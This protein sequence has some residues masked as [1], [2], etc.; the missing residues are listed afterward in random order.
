VAKDSDSRL[1][2]SQL[3]IVFD[4]KT[5][6]SKIKDISHENDLA[7][8]D[9]EA[10]EMIADENETD[11]LL[12]CPMCHQAIGPMKPQPEASLQDNRQY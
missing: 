7:Q 9:E 11:L 10:D 8:V 4:E 12:R 6:R 5:S 2:N 3:I 1:S